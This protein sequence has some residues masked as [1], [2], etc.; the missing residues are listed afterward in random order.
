MYKKE[1]T[2]HLIFQISK[3]SGDI[4]TQMFFQQ[5]NRYTFG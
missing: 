3:R 5:D 1:N 2:L 4:P